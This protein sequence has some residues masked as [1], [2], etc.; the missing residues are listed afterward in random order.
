MVDPFARRAVLSVPSME[1]L[2]VQTRTSGTGRALDV[3]RRTGLG[4]GQVPAVVFIPG[5]AP[6]EVIANAKDWGQYVSWGQLVAS[7][8]LVAVTTNHRS[9]HRYSDLKGAAED[10]DAAMDCV[11]ANGHELGIDTDRMAIWTCSAGG[12][13][14]LRTVLRDRLEFVRAVVALYAVLDLGNGLES[15]SPGLSDDVLAEFSPARYLETGGR[16]PAMLVVRAGRDREVINHSVETFAA[17]AVSAGIDIEYI[18]HAQGQ[19]AFDLLDDTPRSRGIIRRAL[20]FLGE[21]LLEEP[22]AS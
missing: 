14:A 20:D 7:R 8:G 11:R 9:T 1:S 18:N 10:V 15:F 21:T 19:H 3:Y 22:K 2:V 12:P 5:D 4:D 13:M 17:A 16:F 6:Q